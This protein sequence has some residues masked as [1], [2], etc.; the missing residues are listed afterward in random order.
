MQEECI[1][2]N[3]I[4]VNTLCLIFIPQLNSN[5]KTT[6]SYTFPT[7]NDNISNNN[8]VYEVPQSGIAFIN[9]GFTNFQYSQFGIKINEQ[10][11]V[12]PYINAGNNKLIG[13]KNSISFPVKKAIKYELYFTKHMEWIV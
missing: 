12:L 10:F 3:F 9:Y 6:I 11:A 13:Y 8:D 7:S 5:I 4:F 2:W 1:S